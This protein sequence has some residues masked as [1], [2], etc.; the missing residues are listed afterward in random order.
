MA[1]VAVPLRLKLPGVQQPFL[2]PTDDEVAVADKVSE[3]ACL[4]RMKSTTLLQLLVVRP[5]QDSE[6]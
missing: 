3:I 5:A 2:L 4:A 1:K 6:R